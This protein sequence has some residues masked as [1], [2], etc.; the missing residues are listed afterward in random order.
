MAEYFILQPGALT[1]Q[2][3][4]HV[5]N[6]QLKC[7]LAEDAL[8]QINAS[9]QTVKKVILDK[10][11]VYG[12]NTGFGSLANQTISSD[13]LKQLQKNIVLS[14]ACGTGELLSDEIVALILL[15]KINNLAQGYSGVRLE[16][17]ETLISLYNHR[18]YPC[19]P[20][21]GSVG[22][23]GDLA[24]LAHM[25]LPLLGVGDVH[26]QGKK[27]SALEGLKIAGLKP[28]E[29]EAKE[30]LAL[31]N[32]LQVSTAIALT[33]LFAT[34]NLFET[35]LITGALSVD[36]ANGSDVPFDDRIQKV[37][38]H[39]AQ[40]SVAACYRELLAGSQ[41]RE[42]HLDCARVQDPYS[43][44]CQPQIMGAVLH[45]IQ[46]VKETLQVEVNAISDNPLVFSEQEQIISGGNFHGEIVAMAADNLALAIAEIGSNA[47]RRIA[48]LIDKNF[49]NL[50]AF[51]IKESGL[52]SGFM[53]A[54]VTAAAC[55]SE[56]K[57]LA[58]PHSVDSLPTS[59]N[60]EDHVSM[61][62]SA[63]R[64]LHAMNDNTATILAIELLA[65]S[66][67]VEFHK[68]LKSSQLLE[69]VHQRL[70]SYVQPYDSDR[71]FAPDID[72]VKEKILA[73]E[74]TTP[75]FHLWDIK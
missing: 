14:H 34:E 60:Q 46:F 4:K 53:I 71:F 74:F 45:Q 68:P 66:Q 41:I 30:G 67:G 48:L 57:A 15:L 18:I 40:R 75:Y 7:S 59:A 21:K 39:E 12:I 51:L 47:E 62:T 52:N 73:G 10:K 3:I 50:P 29:L 44:R 65:A 63:A 58:H 70:R 49:S 27:I 2:S 6:Q 54:H 16:L 72:L 61:A 33:A 43:L 20:S 9:H 28:I 23:S 25:S 31:L 26:Y 8:T 17:I 64:R 55:A 36:A 56:N 35:A 22:A 1:L 69:E 5:L 38:G 37:R 24:P 32:G 11:T 42:S 13:N 19:I